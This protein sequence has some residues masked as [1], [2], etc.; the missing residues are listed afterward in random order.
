MRKFILIPKISIEDANALSSP[1]SVGF[2]A[3]TAWL[4]AVHALQ[5]KLREQGYEDICFPKSTVSCHDITVRSYRSAGSTYDQLFS[6]RFPIK[7]NGKSASFTVDAT[8][9]LEVSLLIEYENLKLNQINTLLEDIKRILQFDMKLASGN[10]IS[11]GQLEYLKFDDD[12]DEDDQLRPILRKLMLGHVLID[13]RDL[14]EKYMLQGKD[15]LDAILGPLTT[16]SKA[17]VIT[18]VADEKDDKATTD[19]KT[20]KIVWNTSKEEMGWIVP[21]SIGFKAIS[22]AG[23]ALNQ[24]KE[25]PNAEHVFAECVVTLGQFV[26]PYRIDSLEQLLWRYDYDR[27]NNL[28]LC[29]NN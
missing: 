6:K 15:A 12:L 22:P 11:V 26:M 7:K 2:P 19:K 17:Q 3:M 18:V 9:D 8:C 10:V 20:E 4:G 13:R 14:V 29:V 25:N 16:T 27:K 28:Y 5:R 23:K 1:Y 21:T 24:R